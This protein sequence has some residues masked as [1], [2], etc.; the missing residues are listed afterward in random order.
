[1]QNGNAEQSPA[2]TTPGHIAVLVRRSYD[3]DLGGIGAFLPARVPVEELPAPF[4][5]FLAACDELPARYPMGGGG[6]RAWLDGL[7]PTDEPD[8]RRAVARLTGP[9]ADTLMTVLCA[10]GHTYRWDCVPP[11]ASRFKERS[12]GLPPGLAGPWTCL[13]RKLAQPRVGSAWSLHLTNWRLPGRPG[14]AAYE[15]EELAGPALRIART[16]LGPPVDEHLEA[17]SLAFVRMEATGASVIRA[18]VDTVEAAAAGRVDAAGAALRRVRAAVMAM[19]LGFSGNVRTST[20]DPRVWLEL[21]QPTYGWGAQAEEPGRIEGGPSGMQLGTVQGLDAAFTIGQRSSAAQLARAGRRQMPVPHRRFLSTLDLAGPM[22]RRFVLHAG[23]RELTE[24][25]D[26]CISVLGAFRMTHRARGARYLRSRP[27]SDVPRAS[28]GLSIKA[29]D[30]AA[31]VYER[32]MTERIAETNAS[33]LRPGTRWVV[34]SRLAV[35]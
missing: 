22:L 9:E 4:T 25:Y 14:G 28:T 23:S 13:A 1:M 2:M 31:E 10:L 32:T 3:T 34:P 33:V 27:P 5:R 6:V 24:D 26:A 11:L 8:V 29:G 30:D 12:I 7:F 16:W 35:S 18:L 15:P 17:F 20:V 19:T 21:I